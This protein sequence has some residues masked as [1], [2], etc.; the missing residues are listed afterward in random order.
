MP[1]IS[2]ITLKNEKRTDIIDTNP[3][4]SIYPNVTNVTSEPDQS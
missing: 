4:V 1:K 3:I 2:K